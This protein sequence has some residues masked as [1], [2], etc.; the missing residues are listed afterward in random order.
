[1]VSK[2]EILFRHLTCNKQ[3][4]LPVLVKSE[5]LFL[6]ISF[7]SGC[8]LT[9]E[10]WKRGRSNYRKWTRQYNTQYEVIEEGLS[11]WAG[12]FSEG[13]HTLEVPDFKSTHEMEKNDHD[14]AVTL[15]P[16]RVFGTSCIAWK[17]AESQQIQCVCLT[18]LQP[19]LFFSHPIVYSVMISVL[20]PFSD[21]VFLLTYIEDTH[22]VVYDCFNP[23]I[24]DLTWAQRLHVL[25][26]VETEEVKINPYILSSSHRETAEHLLIFKQSDINDVII[27]PMNS[28]FHS[29]RFVSL[30][31]KNVSVE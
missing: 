8:L 7:N 3:V 23:N 22:F 2:R 26:T 29:D 9:T 31:R 14:G 11:K 20:K 13:Y 15:H 19:A 30:D 4:E 16:Q 12:S 18:T 21:Y 27:C 5:T 1:M 17:D 24:K 28:V 10:R 6:K 25:K